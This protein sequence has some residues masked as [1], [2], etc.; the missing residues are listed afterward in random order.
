MRNSPRAK[1]GSV[2]GTSA[3]GVTAAAHTWLVSVREPALGSR[4]RE[5]AP[6][7]VPE[8]ITGTLR[9]AFTPPAAHRSTNAAR[10][11]TPGLRG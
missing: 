8:V 4:G 7:G 1:S 5:A 6:Y 3:L 11:R 2:V 9:R 10:R